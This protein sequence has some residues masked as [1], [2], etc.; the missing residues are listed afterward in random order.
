MDLLG[1]KWKKNAWVDMTLNLTYRAS[2]RFAISL[3]AGP[4]IFVNRDSVK[5][6]MFS[7]GEFN[8]HIGAVVG[9]DLR[10][11]LNDLT[12]IGFD[13]RYAFIQGLPSRMEARVYVSFTF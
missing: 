1:G 10:Y 3:M 12:S 13:A 11:R 2:D 7:L 8:V 9:L 6:G 5:A 4:R